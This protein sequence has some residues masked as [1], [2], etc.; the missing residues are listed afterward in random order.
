MHRGETLAFDPLKTANA[1]AQTVYSGS[2]IAGPGGGNISANG[3]YY[4]IPSRMSS[5]IGATDVFSFTGNLAGSLTI[6]V[7]NDSEDVDFRGQADWHTYVLVTGTNGFTNGVATVAAGVI[8]GGS[9]PGSVQLIDFMFAAY[10]Y[11]FIVTGG[12]GTIKDARQLKGY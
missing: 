8:T 4:S 11:K 6:E 12:T 2:P 9:N 7:M 3:T 1:G 5:M 10:R